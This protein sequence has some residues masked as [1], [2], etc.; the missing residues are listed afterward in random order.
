MK[1]DEIKDIFEKIKNDK[2]LN[3]LVFILGLGILL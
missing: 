2:S 1:L 3:K